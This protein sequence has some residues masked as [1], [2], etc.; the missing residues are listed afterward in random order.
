MENKIHP[1]N[2]AF[3]KFLKDDRFILIEVEDDFEWI[4]FNS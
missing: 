4:I 1:L 3:Q 2:D